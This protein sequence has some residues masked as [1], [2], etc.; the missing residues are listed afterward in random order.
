MTGLCESGNEPLGSLKASKES[1]SRGT[2][3]VK[4][5]EYEDVRRRKMRGGRSSLPS[6]EE[7]P[8]NRC[9]VE[10]WK[11]KMKYSKTK[12]TF[13]NNDRYKNIQYHIA[14]RIDMFVIRYV[15]LS[16]AHIPHRRLSYFK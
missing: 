9:L 8:L 14:K 16:M 11:Q 3:T 6:P 4:E 15:I 1:Q 12:H 10:W 2:A 7:P 13:N 5:D